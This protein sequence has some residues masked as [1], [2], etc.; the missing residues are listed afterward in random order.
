MGNAWLQQACR[1]CRHLAQHPLD[2]HLALPDG[3]APIPTTCACRPHKGCCGHISQPLLECCS[4][5]S[6]CTVSSCLQ[7]WEDRLSARLPLG[8]MRA[9]QPC[10]WHCSTDGIKGIARRQPTKVFCPQS[11]P[12]ALTWR[13]PC[14]MVLHASHLVARS[15]MHAIGLHSLHAIGLQDLA[16]KPSRCMLCYACHT[17][18]VR[19]AFVNGFEP[20]PPL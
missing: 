14:S 20:A 11:M 17:A 12:H 16:C 6:S 4:G 9:Q 3:F 13:A 8:R 19:V 7:L 1:C 15:C 10:L 18:P 5:R 2:P